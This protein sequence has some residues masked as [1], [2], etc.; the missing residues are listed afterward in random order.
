M[1]AE[2]DFSKETEL[3]FDPKV[4]VLS[5]VGSSPSSNQTQLS[6]E[7]SDVKQKEVRKPPPPSTPAKQRTIKIEEYSDEDS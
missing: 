6:K 3:K 1:N 2:K 7:K 4:V 5:L